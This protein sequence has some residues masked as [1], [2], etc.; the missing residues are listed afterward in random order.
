MN[1]FD[2]LAMQHEFT[3]KSQ[4]KIYA[5]SLLTCFWAQYITLSYPCVLI[6]VGCVWVPQIYRN[7]I[8]GYKKS[9]AFSFIV[10][11][12]AHLALLPMYFKGNPYNFMLWKPDFYLAGSLATLIT[13]T[14]TI[15]YIQ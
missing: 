8:Y 4:I 10:V 6:L 14:L 12:L 11:S 15:L 7:T 5:F 2:N 9:P 13:L 3:G 1:K